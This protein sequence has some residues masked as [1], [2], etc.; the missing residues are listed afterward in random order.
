M[1][2]WRLEADP[3]NR[4]RGRRE[5]SSPALYVREGSGGFRC[6]LTLKGLPQVLVLAPQ[7]RYAAGRDAEA[8]GDGIGMI[9][10]RQ[11]GNDAA[12]PV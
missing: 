5:C 4:T 11:A 10:R 9:A 7:L 2:Q 8:T 1:G 6:R 12:V 3:P